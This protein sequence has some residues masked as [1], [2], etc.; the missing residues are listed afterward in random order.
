MRGAG[1]ILKNATMTQV[2]EWVSQFG[3]K[4]YYENQWCL[5]SKQEPGEA[6]F[7]MWL[8]DSLTTG[9]E[10]DQIAE[11]TKLLC[12]EPSVWISV[13]VPGR[14]DGRADV[15]S[16]AISILKKFEG[17]AFD[18]DTNHWWSL[19]DI[20]DNLRFDGHHFFQRR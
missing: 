20:E 13:E 3:T 5:I 18:D 17:V 6:I 7:Y 9:F 8:E 16:F 4:A 15:R 19:A 12:K 11:L 2:T 14:S 10:S 1:I